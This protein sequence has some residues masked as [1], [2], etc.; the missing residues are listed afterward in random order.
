MFVVLL[1]SLNQKSLWWTLRK[2]DVTLRTS[3]TK[4]SL[5]G[6]EKTES[7]EKQFNWLK[8]TSSE[9]AGLP[10]NLEKCAHFTISSLRMVAVSHSCNRRTFLIQH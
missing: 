2:W 5:A 3:T 7:K 10:E 6:K 8:G 9:D 4:P 1:D